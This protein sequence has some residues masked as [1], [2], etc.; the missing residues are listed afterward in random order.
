MLKHVRK[1]KKPKEANNRSAQGEE[2]WK[3]EKILER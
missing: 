2:K 1:E 3:K